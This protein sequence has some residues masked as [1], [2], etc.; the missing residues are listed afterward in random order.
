MA[1]RIDRRFADLKTERRAALVRQ[2]TKDLAETNRELERSRE[3]LRLLGER[4][5]QAKE[6]ES[7]RI[8]RELHDELG[9]ILT[10][11]KIGIALLDKRLHAEQWASAGDYTDRV[12]EILELANGAIRTV[13]RITK[14]LRPAM[15]RSE[16]VEPYA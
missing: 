13:K 10:G 1:T 9:Q 16:P 11:L 5:A 4:L 7:A 12:R 6:E 2:R 8:A 3:H 14:G 15:L